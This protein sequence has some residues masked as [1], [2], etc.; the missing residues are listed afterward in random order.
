MPEKKHPR[1]FE[2][3]DEGESPLTFWQ[4]FVAV[5]A[6]HLGV[7]SRESR[8]QDFKRGNG[9]HFFIAGMIYMILLIIGIVVLV[10]Y[11]V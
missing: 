6:T 2:C 10:S 11:L 1:Y 7:R 3:P 5:L 8:E 4:V 9:L